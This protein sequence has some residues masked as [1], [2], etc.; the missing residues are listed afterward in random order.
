MTV[1]VML[2]WDSDMT[3]T[4]MPLYRGGYNSLIC[5]L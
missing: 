2:R 4:V 3:E 5:S 1:P